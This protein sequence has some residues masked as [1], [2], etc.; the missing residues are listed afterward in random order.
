MDTPEGLG[1]SQG[2][3]TEKRALP[4]FAANGMRYLL[5]TAPNDASG[6][7]RVTDLLLMASRAPQHPE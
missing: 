2:Y 5:E 3:L 6:C 4:P 7:R 1:Y